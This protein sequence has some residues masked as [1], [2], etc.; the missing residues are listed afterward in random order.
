M[1]LPPPDIHL[2]AARRL[3]SLGVALLA[4]LLGFGP[5]HS[6]VAQASCAETAHAYGCCQ[7][8]SVSGLEFLKSCVQARRLDLQPAVPAAGAKPAA[9]NPLTCRHYG[10]EFSNGPGALAADQ[11]AY[12]ERCLEADIVFRREQARR[13]SRSKD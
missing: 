9:V 10:A 2:P 1:S 3:P 7:L 6:A 8:T 12:L 5:A 4:L 13:Q 11:L